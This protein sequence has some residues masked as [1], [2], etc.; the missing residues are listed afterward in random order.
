M[1]YIYKYWITSKK[2]GWV[3]YMY[4]VGPPFGINSSEPHPLG[5]HQDVYRLQF[6][7]SFEVNSVN[8]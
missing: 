6:F 7:S 1:D 3:K 2:S 8:R 5:K 4:M